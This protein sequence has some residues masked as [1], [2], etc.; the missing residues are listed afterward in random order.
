MNAA[1][2]RMKRIL[3]V[4]AVEHRIAQMRLAEADNRLLSL[5]RISQRIDALRAGAGTDAGITDG[6]MLKSVGEMAMRLE[7]AQRDMAA[8]V[9]AASARRSILEAERGSAWAREER[10]ARL[11]QRAASHAETAQEQRADA[12]RPARRGAKNHPLSKKEQSA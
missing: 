5:A 11:H 8:P 1:A 3:R 4:R 2:A 6:L 12:N 9:E 10:A 7:I